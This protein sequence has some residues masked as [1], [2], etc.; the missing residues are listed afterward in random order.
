MIRWLINRQSVTRRSWENL[1]L[2]FVGNQFEGGLISKGNHAC[3]C[4][5]QLAVPLWMNK[6]PYNVKGSK[7]NCACQPS[8]WTTLFACPYLFRTFFFIFF[9]TILKRRKKGKRGSSIHQRT[10]KGRRKRRRK[11]DWLLNLVEKWTTRPPR[12]K[13]LQ[14][15]TT[16]TSDPNDEIFQ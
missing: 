11:I 16:T 3:R 6:S 12:W 8:E 9:Y 10:R 1:Q 14:P 15:Q 7:F 13:V 4:I 2:Y 5:K